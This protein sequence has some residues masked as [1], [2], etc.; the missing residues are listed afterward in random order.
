MKF[1]KHGKRDTNLLYTFFQWHTSEAHG[2]ILFNVIESHYLERSYLSYVI[3]LFK[4][5]GFKL[6]KLFGF[7]NTYLCQRL[8]STVLPIQF[9]KMT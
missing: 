4:L 2:H 3:K 5:F 6:F 9:Q 1:C 8:S 7:T